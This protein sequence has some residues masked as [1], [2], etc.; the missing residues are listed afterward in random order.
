MWRT[1]LS[2]TVLWLA[3]TAQASAYI[4]YVSNEKANTVS[5]IDTENWT[6]TKTI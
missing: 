1:L 4:A 6:V 2:V 3:A 5:V